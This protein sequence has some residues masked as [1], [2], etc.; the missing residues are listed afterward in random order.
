MARVPTDFK[1]IAQDLHD[2]GWG[3]TELEEQTG[4][5]RTKFAKL[6]KGTH[7]QRV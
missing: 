6:R 2:W 1:K 4:V 3:G 7:K 5:D